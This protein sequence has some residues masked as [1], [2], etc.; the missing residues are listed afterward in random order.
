MTD[1]YDFYIN[2]VRLEKVKIEFTE[3]TKVQVKQFADKIGEV[4]KKLEEANKAFDA[5][6]FKTD[7][8]EY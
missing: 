1:F 2:V 4:D 8:I 7:K 5:W 6:E 3:V